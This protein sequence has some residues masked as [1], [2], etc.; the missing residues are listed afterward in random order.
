M[1]GHIAGA[2]VRN[3][4]AAAVHMADQAGM[5]DLVQQGADQ[6]GFAGAVLA[7]ENGELAAVDMHGDV[8][9]E[10]LAAA[11]DGDPVQIDVAELA[12][13]QGHGVPASLKFGA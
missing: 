7:D 2:K 3:V 8:L 11:A 4:Q 9:E 13:M 12:V 6:G 1:L 5:G 10:G